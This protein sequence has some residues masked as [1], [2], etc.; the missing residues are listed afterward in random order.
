MTHPCDTA[1]RSI[2]RFPGLGLA[3]VLAAFCLLAGPGAAEETPY[4]IHQG[5]R[6]EI[7]VF[8]APDQ[9]GEFPVDVDGTVTHP[10]AGAVQALGR[11]LTDVQSDLAE[12]LGAYIPNP[13][14]AVGIAAYAP[15]YVVGD[16]EQNGEFTYRPGM[17]ALQLLAMAG[18]P[19][20]L[21]LP[22][23]D[24]ALAIISAERD[25]ADIS[26]RI[27][28]EEVAMARFRAELGAGDA[29]IDVRPPAVV[30]REDAAA[31]LENERR[32][33][34]LRRD[35]RTSEDA[36]LAAQAE[37]FES[38]IAFLQKSIALHD[39][40]LRLLDEDVKAATQLV[41]RGLSTPAKLR[42]VQ[43]TQSATRR[44]AL[45]LQAALAR[46]R[47]GSLDVAR[48]RNDAAAAFRTAA[49][50]G[51][52]QAELQL[53]SLR[54]ALAGVE[55]T[56][57]SYA[58]APGKSLADRSAIPELSV[59]RA[60]PEGLVETAVAENAPLEPGDVLR[61]ERASADLSAPVR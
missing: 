26:L 24:G 34:G 39:E 5:D 44:D 40:E 22:E 1:A 25:Y 27:F 50:D 14:L 30:G 61:V 32:L 31:I 48:R 2:A 29:A 7:R 56:L 11:S 6:I 46:A 19:R 41:E 12:R 10:L 37:S 20:R 36:G 15:V 57:T 60:G 17:T 28:S 49:G 52:R 35:A 43:R 59:L 55:K 16:A 21:V 58:A 51:L 8:G 4:L 53:A 18:G 38:E 23:K 33:L 3:R 9:S 42:E 45:D 13:S 47:Q 54:L